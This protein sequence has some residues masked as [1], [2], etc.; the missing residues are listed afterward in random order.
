MIKQVVKFGPCGRCGSL[1]RR[2]DLHSLNAK[3]YSPDDSEEKIPI[4]L[5]HKCRAEVQSFLEGMRWDNEQMVSKEVEI[6]L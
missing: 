3:L 4:R 2:D 6:C 5:C 1:V